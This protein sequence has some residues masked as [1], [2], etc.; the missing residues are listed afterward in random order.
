[1][2]WGRYL[3]FGYMDPHKS[4]NT[5]LVDVSCSRTSAFVAEFQPPM[6]YPP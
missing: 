2:V 3:L 5:Q 6:P 1:M 4:F